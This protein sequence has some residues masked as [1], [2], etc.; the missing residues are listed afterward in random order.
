GLAKLARD[1]DVL[2]I[3]LDIETRAA[4]AESLALVNGDDVHNLGVTGAGVTV[5]VL[6]T[7]ADSGHP[8]LKGSIVAE[9]CFSSAGTCPGGGSSKTGSGAAKDDNGHGTNVTGIIAGRGHVAPPG[10]APAA[11]IVSIKVLD[12][13]GGGTTTDMVSGLDYVLNSRPEV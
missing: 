6:D 9:A 2:A 3:D 11:N 4:M 1:P 12:A 13:G 10:M 8:D 7:G 5:A